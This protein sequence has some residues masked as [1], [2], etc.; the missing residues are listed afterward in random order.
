MKAVIVEASPKPE[1]NS[2]TIAK[3]II[4]GLRENPEAEIT[5]LF[6]DELDIKFCRGCWKCLKRGEPGCVIDFNDL[7]V[8]TIVDSHK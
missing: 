5:E 2:T 8:P 3:H 7:I 4:N 6:L 1:G